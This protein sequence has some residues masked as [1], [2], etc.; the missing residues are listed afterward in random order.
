DIS[1]GSNVLITDDPTFDSGLL[2]DWD[3]C[4]VKDGQ[5]GSSWN[6]C[7]GT[8]QFM[9]ADL[10]MDPDT[11]HSFIH[12][13]KSTFYVVLWLALQYMKNSWKTG[14]CSN[15]INTTMNPQSFG[16]TGGRGKVNFM[17]NPMALNDFSITSN[18]PLTSLIRKLK[19]P[20]CIRYVQV[21]S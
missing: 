8:W 18:D 6:A 14:I 15:F 7:M 20:L 1:S 10:V 21:P 16:N 4:K 2:I 13:L 12:D 17:G 19:A 9:A 11:T 5:G 3:M